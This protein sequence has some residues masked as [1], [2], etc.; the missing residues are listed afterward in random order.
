VTSGG[1]NFNDFPE[2]QLSK[3]FCRL[4]SIKA[5]HVHAFFCSMQ[6]LHFCKPVWWN[7][8]ISPFP[9][10]LISLGERRFPKKYMGNV[11][12]RR[13]LSLLCLCALKAGAGLLTFISGQRH[14]YINVTILRSA[15]STDG[16]RTFDVELLNPSGGASVGV[17]STV[18]VTLLAG[19]HAFGIFYFADQ[20]L[21]VTV[22]E[23]LARPVVEA[24]F[25][26]VTL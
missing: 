11:I 18:S 16:D 15:N 24:T 8:T 19:T 9:F 6:D 7:A 4:S 17:A 25:Q 14:T 1:N 26:V 20:S 21:S 2:N 5:N 10:I 23:D 12:S 3:F 13:S 22:A